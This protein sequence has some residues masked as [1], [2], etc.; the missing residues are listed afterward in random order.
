MSAQ[1]WKSFDDEHGR[2]RANGTIFPNYRD[3][4]WDKVDLKSIG[5]LIQLFFKQFNT[6]LVKNVY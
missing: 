5:Y 4:F 1:F 2:Y 6:E 3:I